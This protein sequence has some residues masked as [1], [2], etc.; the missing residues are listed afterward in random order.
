M[1]RIARRARFLSIVMGLFGL[2]MVFFLT[3]YMKNGR[4]WVVHPA[5]QNLYTNGEL[6]TSGTIVSSDG[7]TLLT[8]N[9]DGTTYADKAGVRKATL[10][11]VGDTNENIITGAYTKYKSE[12]IGYSF[13]DG[14]YAPGNKQSKIELTIDA[15]LSNTAYKALGNYNG[16]VGVYNYETG[17]IL[18]MV[19]KPTYDPEKK[20]PDVTSSYYKGVYINRLTNGLYPP[21]SIMK[22]VT[23]AAAIENIPN[24]YSKTF[25]CRGGTTIDGQFIKC[26]G[27]H[28][29]VNFENGLAH[30]CNAV[31][32]TLGVELGAETLTKYAEM[33]GFKT[34]FNISG[35]D[36]SKGRFDVS[37][38]DNVALAWAAIGQH[39]TMVNPMQY[40]IFMGA[41]AKDG[42]ATTPYYVNKVQGRSIIPN[43]LQFD[44]KGKKADRMLNEDTAAKLKKL[45]RNNV[46]VKYGDYNFSGMQLCAKT[47]TAEVEEGE[48]HTWF[49]GFSNNSK[50][51]LA[52]VVIAEH[53][54]SS[55][56]A[57]PI[58]K[59]V[60]NKAVKK[61]G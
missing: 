32:G 3:D 24:I 27:Y 23:A 34:S 51:P 4:E 14:L 33:A 50:T 17:E 8:L 42:Q 52:F 21:G 12:L 40:M 2:C 45:M 22:V 49:V 10:H 11:A 55:N 39:T 37:N 1:K 54:T 5:N 38:A 28:G 53:G 19:S 58:A 16:T 44:G 13:V 29:K 59:T 46:K 35:V 47:G 60:M 25:T 48:P 15:D 36:T 26:A 41:I 61:V 43:F 20:L 57:I 6:T 56:T 31:F 7:T 30:S 18:C 9:D